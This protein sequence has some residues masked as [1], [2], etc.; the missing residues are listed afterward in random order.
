MILPTVEQIEALKPSELI[1][2][3]QDM[4][5]YRKE[6]LQRAS[7]WVHTHRQIVKEMKA[8]MDELEMELLLAEEDRMNDAVHYDFLCRIH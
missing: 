3:K 4:N 8:R 2:L 6:L 5:E 7:D 1:Q